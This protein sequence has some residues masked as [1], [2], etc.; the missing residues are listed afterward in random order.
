MNSERIEAEQKKI[1][2]L[3]NNETV[4]PS[5]QASMAQTAAILEVALQLA[6]IREE[7]IMFNSLGD[8]E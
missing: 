2:D 7:R 4:S 1:L 3:S 6:L 8:C 5:L